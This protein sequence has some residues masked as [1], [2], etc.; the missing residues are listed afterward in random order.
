MCGLEQGREAWRMDL[1]ERTVLLQDKYVKFEV[2][3]DVQIE[4]WEIWT[5][6]SEGRAREGSEGWRYNVCTISMEVITETMGV[7]NDAQGEEWQEMKAHIR[8]LRNT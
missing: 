1:K 4:V 2:S 8:A 6:S 3:E 5:W 7:D